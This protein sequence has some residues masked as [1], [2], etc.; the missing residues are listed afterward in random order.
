MGAWDWESLAGLHHCCQCEEGRVIIAGRGAREEGAIEA[1]SPR[2]PHAYSL[3]TSPSRPTSH[4]PAG[5]CRPLSKT[6]RFNVIDHQV[7]KRAE[8]AAKQFG[9]F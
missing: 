6:I 8:K 2:P 5:Q 1:D 9:R 7:N 3:L 4:P